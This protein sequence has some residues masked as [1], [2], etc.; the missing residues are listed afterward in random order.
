MVFRRPRQVNNIAADAWEIIAN[1][2]KVEFCASFHSKTWNWTNNSE[3][4]TSW[5][6]RNNQLC[7]NYIFLLLSV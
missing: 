3:C 2:S 6:L 1:N 7:F 5:N 4:D